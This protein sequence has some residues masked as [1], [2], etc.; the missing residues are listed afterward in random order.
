MKTSVIISLSCLL[1]LVPFGIALGQGQITIDHV[2]GLSQEG[3]LVS[4][5]PV[6]FY[7]RLTNT[8]GSNIAG[9]TNGFR[10][11]SPDGAVWSP[12]VADSAAINWSEMYDGGLYFNL[13]SADGSLS[14]TLGF[15]GYAVYKGGI[16]VGFDGVAYTISTQLSAAQEGLTLCLDSCFYRPVGYWFWAHA[17]S[18]NST[19]SWDGPHCYQVSGCCRGRTGDINGDGGSVP[20]ISDLVFLVNYMFTAGPVPPCMAATDIDGNGSDVPDISDLVALVS[21]MF[22]GGAP[23]ANCS[24]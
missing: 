19:P 13:F 10:L 24:R 3:K 15:G 7:L 4:G 2:D 12:P 16:P 11:Y 23:P 22:G 17:G 20:D 6:T 9:S 14:D 21:Y 1:M 8:T 18:S 5:S